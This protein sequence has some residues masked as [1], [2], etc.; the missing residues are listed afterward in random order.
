M[1]RP[2]VSVITPTWQRHRGLTHLCI[3]SVQAQTYEH[4]EQ[5]IVSDGPDPFLGPRLEHID[6]VRYAELAVHHDP[7]DWGV[8]ARLHAL[9][10]AKGD[11][12]A[13]LD[14]DNAYR[15]DHLQRLVEAFETNPA[16]EFAY[17]RME[18]HWGG[19]A[20]DEV[21]V[22]PPTYGRIDT[23]LLMHRPGLLEVATWQP[24]HPGMVDPHAVD[25]DL[26]SRWVAAGARWTH[27]PHVTLDYY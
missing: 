15:P 26:I 9:E 3:P 6:G 20:T 8:A 18:R 23:S 12:I 5:V 17:S 21:G 19:G 16:V 2:L 24:P 7:P 14:D 22:A 4:V 10:L 13:Y 25:W 1:N 11:L 27:I